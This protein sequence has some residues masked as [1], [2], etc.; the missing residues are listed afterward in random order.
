MKIFKMSPVLTIAFL[1]VLAF[2]IPSAHALPQ[3]SGTCLPLRGA[4]PTINGVISSGEW[5]TTPAFVLN[6]P[7]Y[8]IQ[9]NVY[10]MND[11][12]NLYIL[13]D[14][15]ADNTDDNTQSPCS[16]VNVQHCDECLLIFG[17]ANQT[18]R[19]VAEVWGTSTSE[20]GRNLHFPAGAE[21][22]IGFNNHRFYEWKIPL[23][24]INAVPGQIIDFSSPKLCKMVGYGEGCFYQASMPY[25]GSTGND[26]DWPLGVI[27][28]DRS[29][30]AK[31]QANN[32][33]TSVPTLTEWGMIVFMILAGLGAVYYLRRQRRSES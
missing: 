6:P 28:G 27:P 1:M 9:T 29:T 13:V 31:L 23:G 2:Y 5:P 20:V 4:P 7:D 14:A 32:G 19:H 16:S 11:S 8:P 21:V 3:P 12:V 18:S 15:L 30:W 22:A 24:S 25:D 33:I 10:C 17:D 26:N